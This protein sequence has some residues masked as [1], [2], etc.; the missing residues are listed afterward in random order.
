MIVAAC[1]RYRKTEEA[2]GDH[3]DAIVAL[4]GARYFRRA[5][6]VIPG[7]E[8]NESRAG[9]RLVPSL[10]VHQVAGNL[11]LGELIVRYV[12]VEGLDHPVAVN[13]S[14]WIGVKAPAHGIETAIIVLAVA[15]DIEPCAS[16]ALAIMRRSQ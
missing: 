13:I 9:K 1:A 5:I 10:G 3:I 2:T 7:A 14:I 11:S 16:P 4:I 15:G 12:V 8:A 6:I